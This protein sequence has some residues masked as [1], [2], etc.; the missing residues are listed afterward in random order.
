MLLSILLPTR[1]RRRRVVPLVQFLLAN[2]PEQMEGAW[3]LVVLD[4]ASEDGTG[5]KL[6]ALS[7]PRMRVITNPQF[8]PTSEENVMNGLGHARGTFVWFLGDDDLPRVAAMQHMAHL[9]R[10]D[11]ADLMVFN[12]R[13]MDQDGNLVSLTQ[14]RGLSEDAELTMPQLIRR[15]G[16]INMLSGWSIIVARRDMLDVKVMRA[17]MAH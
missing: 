15:A 2:M 1:N 8:L 6:R 12:F 4:N 13:V 9:L 11:T 7:D 16:L 3:E 5:D 17:I 10:A 14:V